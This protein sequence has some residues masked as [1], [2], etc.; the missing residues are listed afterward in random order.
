MARGWKAW[1]VPFILLP[2]VSAQAGN[3]TYCVGGY[4]GMYPSVVAACNQPAVR[5]QHRKW[6]F[7]SVV[8]DGARCFICYDE[9]D[10]TCDIDFLV[11]T[12]RFHR[13]ANPYSCDDPHSADELIAHVIAGKVVDGP[14]ASPVQ[15][16]AKVERLTPGPYTAGDRISVTGAVRDE[17]GGIRKLAG[18]SFR[19]TDSAGQAID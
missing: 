7:H 19:V 17:G 2:A 9:Q 1:L 18:G 10:D 15:L 11:N 5:R 12:P 3:N 16:E 4:E 8:S 14:P 13:V 6:H